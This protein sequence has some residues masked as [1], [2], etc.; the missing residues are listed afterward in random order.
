MSISTANIVLW[1]V[2][3]MKLCCMRSVWDQAYLRRGKI[4]TLLRWSL[5]VLEWFAPGWRLGKEKEDRTKYTLD[6]GSS[7]RN[8]NTG[9]KHKKARLKTKLLCLLKGTTIFQAYPR[10]MKLWDEI[11]MLTRVQHLHV[12]MGYE[13]RFSI[14]TLL[15]W[16]IV[17]GLTCWGY[18]VFHI[19]RWQIFYLLGLLGNG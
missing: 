1:G 8:G 15:N 6:S 7:K 3:C 12:Q 17:I 18:V 19:F 16:Q 10:W 11:F 14:R 5:L 9:A 2:I 4:W 13:S